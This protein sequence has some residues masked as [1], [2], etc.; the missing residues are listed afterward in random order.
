[1]CVELTGR[2]NQEAIITVIAAERA[3][4]YARSGLSFVICSPTLRINFGPNN[5]KP[6]ERPNAPIAITHMGIDTFDTTSPSPTV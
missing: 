6:K 5:N 3:T 2:A 4:Q 1:M